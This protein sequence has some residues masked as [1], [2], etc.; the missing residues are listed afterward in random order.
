MDF[1]N[2]LSFMDFNPST[3]SHN[4]QSAKLWHLLTPPLKT[5]FE[6]NAID[7]SW[8]D[9][10][11]FKLK[12]C[13][14][15]LLKSAFCIFRHFSDTDICWDVLKSCAFRYRRN[16]LRSPTRSWKLRGVFWCCGNSQ[17][18]PEVALFQSLL[19]YSFLVSQRI[20]IN[21]NIMFPDH[22]NNQ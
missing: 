10:K 12:E 7:S 9:W 20:V 4:P 1:K 14:W 19:L 8:I 18:R 15:V 21:P 13:G 6:L 3:S 11:R 17:K 16:N 5:E 2:G 22:E